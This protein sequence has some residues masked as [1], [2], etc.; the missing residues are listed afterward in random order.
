[1]PRVRCD[2]CGKQFNNKYNL[3]LHKE[4]KDCAEPEERSD[5]VESDRSK[6]KT[7]SKQKHV[8]SEATGTVATFFEDRGFGFVV[9]ADITEISSGG[10]ESTTDVF[11]HITELD[12]N[13]VE[14]GDRLKFE[15]YETADGFAAKDCTV[16]E[17]DKNRDE[18]NK[19]ED[20]PAKRLGFGQ[21]VDDSR[22]GPGKSRPTNSDIENFRDRRKFR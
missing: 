6:T 3:K 12:T 18:Y 10:I 14:E 11:F 2:R 16:L 1:M 7:K 8:K 5:P 17:R 4:L 13:W 22:Y 20:D 15:V 19:E 21:Q 9:T